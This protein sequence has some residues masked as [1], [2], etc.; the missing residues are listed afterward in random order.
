LARAVRPDKLCLAALGTTLEHYLRGEAVELIPIWQMISRTPG[1]IKHVAEGWAQSVG[2]GD[3]VQGQSTVGGGSL[4][5]ETL[6]TW[7][8]ALRVDHPQ[9]FLAR[10]RR[11]DP[12]IIA[13]V[14]QDLACFDPRTVLPAEEE[15]FLKG[16]RAACAPMPEPAADDDL[17]EA[18]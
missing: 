4:P 16:L 14:N 15:S 6:P 1:A 17:K 2:Q 9:A 18:V 7:L 13:R 11:Q 12:P 5:E 3:V 8:L 10:L